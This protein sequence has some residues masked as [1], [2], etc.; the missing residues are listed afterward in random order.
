ML[1]LFPLRKREWGEAYLSEF[2]AD[3]GLIRLL[4]HAWALTLKGEDIMHTV[5][6]TTSVVNG[7]FGMF[8]IGLYMVT[9]G[10][11]AVVLLLALGLIV[12]GGYTL[13]YLAGQGARLEPWPTR[14]L[15]AGETVAVLIGIGGLLISA[16]SSV[17]A[18]N[19]PEYGPMAVAGLIAAQSAAALYTYAIRGGAV[20][21]DAPH[22]Y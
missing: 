2:G 13:W 9:S 15:I 6:A 16:V 22:R 7:L 3:R 19:D 21:I 17:D 1:R 5:V 14:A 11:P 8:L 20:S 4:I 10:N 18:F 12:Q